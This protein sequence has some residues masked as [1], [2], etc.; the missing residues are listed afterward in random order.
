MPKITSKDAISKSKLKP[1]FEDEITEFKGRDLEQN[2]RMAQLSLYRTF[3]ATYPDRFYYQFRKDVLK[4]I[5]SN[6]VTNGSIMKLW[7]DPAPW[8]SLNLPSRHKE[9]FFYAFAYTYRAQKELK[10][11]SE[12]LA[13]P[14]FLHAIYHIGILDSFT[15]MYIKRKKDLEAKSEG[16]KISSSQHDPLR[17]EAARLIIK[18]APKDGWKTHDAAAD[19]IQKDLAAFSNP[20]NTIYHKNKTPQEIEEILEI[21]EEKAY[22]T[23]RRL[24]NWK[25]GVVRQAYELS[26]TPGDMKP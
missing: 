6:K 13:W 26:C 9:D 22:E 24:L 1:T 21:Q 5:N 10:E 16:G 18:L 4:A 15:E 23:V 2:I 3:K 12:S 14:I 25:D 17:N 11:N 19:G 20:N 7:S 8:E